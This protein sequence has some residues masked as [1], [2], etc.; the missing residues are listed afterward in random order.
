VLSYPKFALSEEKIKE[1][2]GGDPSIYRSGQAKEA[3]AR[4]LGR[5]GMYRE[6]DFLFFL[7]VREDGKQVLRLR[8]PLSPNIRI[9]LLGDLCIAAPSFSKPTV[10]LI[11][12]RRM[13]FPVFKHRQREGTRR[14]R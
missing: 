9:K 4:P 11:W 10:A 8:V 2:P 1:Y 13:G 3:F 12:S 5:F 7:N 6:F 14:L